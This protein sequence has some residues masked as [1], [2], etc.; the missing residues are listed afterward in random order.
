MFLDVKDEFS[1]SVSNWGRLDFERPKISV[2]RLIHERVKLELERRDALQMSAPVT[3]QL[4]EHEKRLNQQKRP[5]AAIRLLCADG[6]YARQIANA[7]QAFEA[8]QY[9]VL[10]DDRQATY[11]DELI[12]I[13]RTGEVTFLLLTPLQGG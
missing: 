13:E 8:N 12:D 10:L 2:R 1:G 6:P 4:T 5:Q 9:F 7:E 11:L 3:V